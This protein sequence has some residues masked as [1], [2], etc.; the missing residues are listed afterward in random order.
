ML[1]VS[2]HHRHIAVHIL[3][4][5]T[6]V[7]QGY[8]F[9]FDIGFLVTSF[10]FLFSIGTIHRFLFFERGNLWRNDF[11]CVFFLFLNRQLGILALRALIVVGAHVLFGFCGRHLFDST[12]SLEHTTSRKRFI[13]ILVFV[14]LVRIAIDPFFIVIVMIYRNSRRRWV[15]GFERFFF[16]VREVQKWIYYLF[17]VVLNLFGGF[18]LAWGCRRVNFIIVRIFEIRCRRWIFASL[19]IFQQFIN[20]RGS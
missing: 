15:A 8:L 7:G 16:L 13:N 2:T 17:L 19:F 5:N 9:N 14:R 3:F 6:H 18:H 12:Q 1:R 4:N 11:L 20:W 10:W